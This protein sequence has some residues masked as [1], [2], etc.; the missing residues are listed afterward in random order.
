MFSGPDLICLYGPPGS[1]KSSVGRALAARLGLPFWDL[2]EEIQARSKMSIPEIFSREGER[3][4]RQRERKV[5]LELTSRGE[6]VLALGGGALLNPANRKRVEAVGLVLCLHAPIDRLLERLGAQGDSRPLLSG[7]VRARLESL[8]SN[9]ADHYRLFPLALD[10]DQPLERIVRDAQV[11]LGS[12]HV[13]GMGSGY[14]VRVQE[15]GLDGIGEML[16]KRGLGSPVIVVTDENVGQLYSQRVLASLQSAKYSAQA[17]SI[18]SG[19][20]HKTLATVASLWDGFVAAGIERNSTVIALGGGVVGD[21]AGFAAATILR[22]VPWV[23]LPTSL[24]AMVD[25]SLGGKTGFDLSQGKNLVGTFHP[26][27]LVLADPFTLKT[28]PQAELRAGM[29]EVVKAG[30]IGDAQLFDLCGRGWEAVEREIGEMVRRSMA[31]KISVIEDDPYEKGRRAALNLGHTVGHAVELVSGFKLRHGEAIAI[32]LVAE[33]R[34]AERV[35]IADQ[36]LASE[37][38]NVLRQ[39]GLPVEVPLQMDLGAI[40]QAMQVDKKRL[41]GKVRFALPVRPGEVRVGVEVEHDTYTGFT[42]SQS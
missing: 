22:G 8:L 29:A 13:R 9:R 36:G 18:P 15:K 23:A 27:R 34:L 3:G 11:R 30:L 17:I 21:L 24:L 14:D 6:G 35:G 19:E 5:L 2:D 33:A 25:A 1:G 42:R 12:Y 40:W 7:D 38:E 4:F 41:D 39:L 10:T 26:P 31:V 37:I 20:Q 16:L 32:G 28:L